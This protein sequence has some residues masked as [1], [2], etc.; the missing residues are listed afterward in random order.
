MKSRSIVRAEASDIARRRAVRITVIVRLA[1][2]PPVAIGPSLT[3]RTVETRDV[4]G[5]S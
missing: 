4:E 2:R 3:D 5:V 1:G